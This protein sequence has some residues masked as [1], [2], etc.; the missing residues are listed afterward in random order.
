MGIIINEWDKA[1]E[2]Y[3]VDQENSTFVEGTKRI[4]KKRFQDLRG[5]KVLDLGCGYG[6]YSEYFRT[7]GADVV[8]ID[9]SVVMIN[10]AKNK[11]PNNKYVVCDF[12][13]RLPF[14]NNEFDIV[15]CNQVLMD[16]ENISLL[17]SES[18]RILKDNGILGMGI[19]H[20]AFYD[21]VW[22]IDGNGFKHSKAISRYIS[23]YSPLMSPT[24]SLS[25]ALDC[26]LAELH[27]CEK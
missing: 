10:M 6:V 16:I 23:E 17:M 11:Y 4:V 14:D 25:E 5:K 24:L 12:E 22:Q 2:Q 21:G 9:G 18:R 26:F 3:A 7:I 13:N 8:G 19:V 20:P 1:A 27:M 15:F